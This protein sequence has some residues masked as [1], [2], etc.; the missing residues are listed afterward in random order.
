MHKLMVIDSQAAIARKAHNR[1][2]KSPREQMQNQT[3]IV[4]L[5][6]KRSGNLE[7]AIKWPALVDWNSCNKHKSF[8]DTRS[9]LPL[10]FTSSPH[11]ITLAIEPQTVQTTSPF[12]MRSFLF[13]SKV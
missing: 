6:F 3:K 8:R 2:L 7:W 13:F 11:N 9:S 10:Q 12:S 1:F 5:Y 4:I